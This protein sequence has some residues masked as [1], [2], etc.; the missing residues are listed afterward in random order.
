MSAFEQMGDWQLDL[1]AR[2][3]AS[4]LRQAPP[5]SWDEER[6]ELWREQY[7]ALARQTHAEIARRAG[8]QLSLQF[9]LKHEAARADTMS[10]MH[11][12]S[13]HHSRS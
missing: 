3:C 12:P 2:L 9:A 8:Q 13:K 4:Q 6:V 5:M 10:T 11:A 1:C 7:R